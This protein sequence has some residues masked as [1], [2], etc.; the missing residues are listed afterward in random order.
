MRQRLE[1]LLRF[2]HQRGCQTS[3]EDKDDQ[4]LTQIQA[5]GAFAFRRHWFLLP[6]G[7]CASVSPSS[8]VTPSS[9]SRGVRRPSGLT[10]VYLQVV[11]CC[12]L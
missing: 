8:K 12:W 2:K 4:K 5:P 7:C 11:L 9:E 10:R 1:M 6:A 3:Q